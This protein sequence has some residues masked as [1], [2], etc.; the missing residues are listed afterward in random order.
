MS[1]NGKQV[2]GPISNHD[3]DVYDPFVGSGTTIIAGD[4]LKRKVYAMELSPNYIDVIVARY[5]KY[6]RETASSLV[7]KR[8]GQQLSDKEINKFIEN[9]NAN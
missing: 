8:N 2:L 5:A 3:G 7:I 9:T 1:K 6:K 4:Q